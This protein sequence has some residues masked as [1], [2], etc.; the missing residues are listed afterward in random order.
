MDVESS[1]Q[2]PSL[3][4]YKHNQQHISPIEAVA[5]R[6]DNI[7]PMDVQ[8]DSRIGANDDEPL[9]ST[10]GRQARQLQH[11]E[12]VNRVIESLESNWHLGLQFRNECWSPSKSKK[13]DSERCYECIKFLFFSS[14]STLDRCLRVFGRQAPD[15]DSS[16]ARLAFL[17]GLLE[18]E[19]PKPNGRN[20]AMSK[21]SLL[22]KAPLPSFSERLRGDVQESSSGPGAERHP[23]DPSWHTVVPRVPQYVVR[24]ALGDDGQDRSRSLLSRDSCK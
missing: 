13:N 19:C 23:N 7:K 12:R 11:H 18:S 21:E 24:H 5:S 9:P 6:S 16:N 20:K 10:P 8:Y 4:S 1:Q 22:V 15:L 14:K 2:Q 3:A 17:L